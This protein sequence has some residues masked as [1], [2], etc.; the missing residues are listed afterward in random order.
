VSMDDWKDHYRVLQVHHE[1]EKDVIE[2]AHRKLAARY[3]PDVNKDPGATEKMRQINV[4][5]DVLTDPLQRA[6]YDVLWRAHQPSGGPSSA[7]SSYGGSGGAAVPPR[8]VA[9]PAVLTVGFA[10]GSPGRACFTLKNAG[11]PY[12]RIGLQVPAGDSSWL[13]VLS[14]ESLT[15]GDE[16]PMK[17]TV[18][19]QPVDGRRERVCRV[20]AS[21]DGESV[22]VSVVHMPQ[23]SPPRSSGAGRGY[24]APSDGP[25]RLREVLRFGMAAAGILL[26]VPGLL[27]DILLLFAAL[28]ALGQAGP[29]RTAF[30]MSVMAC[31][32]LSLL[33]VA[34]GAALLR[35]G[36]ME[37]APA[38]KWWRL[39]LSEVTADVRWLLPL[40]LGAVGG[41][42]AWRRVR[43]GDRGSALKMLTWGIAVSV[44][45][46]VLLAL[47]IVTKPA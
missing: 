37:G 28:T 15:S 36:L 33:I 27:F 9:D 7:R 29:D 21:L 35:R 3:H 30:C 22:E 6:D 25:I 31:A 46:P 42:M 20:L 11:G 32:A 8:P 39:S 18:E 38:Q 2:A 4:A 47:L 19:A 44:V 45:Q 26:L 13:Q 34:P 10:D 43:D 14:Y 17:V 16:L 41:L 40:G 12:G 1:A 23:Y 5:R 24:S